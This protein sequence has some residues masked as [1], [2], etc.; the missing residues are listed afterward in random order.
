LILDTD[1]RKREQVEALKTLLVDGNSIARINKFR[2]V[3]AFP[4]SNKYA[5]VLKKHFGFEDGHPI[6]VKKVGSD[7]R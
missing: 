2:V 7:G 6:L 3:Y 1:K 5:D 4:D